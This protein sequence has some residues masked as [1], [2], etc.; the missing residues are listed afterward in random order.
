[1]KLF[2]FTLITTLMLSFTAK[3]D[4]VVAADGSGDVRSVQAAVDKVSENNRKRV[5]I[6]IKSGVYTE[7]VRVPANKPFVSFIGESA[8]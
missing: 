3:A 5:V 1:M 7:Q 4:I 2:F 8:E 6:R